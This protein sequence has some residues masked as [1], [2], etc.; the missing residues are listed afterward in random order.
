MKP[1][2]ITTTATSQPALS[3]SPVVVI[4][5]AEDTATPQQSFETKPLTSISIKNNYSTGGNASNPFRLLLETDHNYQNFYMDPTA[6]ARQRD[7]KKSNG[8]TSD[9]DDYNVYFDSGSAE[10]KSN[11]GGVN[12][13]GCQLKKIDEELSSSFSASSASLASQASQSKHLLPKT[14][15]G[16][17]RKSNKLVKL[18]TSFT[19]SSSSSSTI[20]TTSQ[21]QTTSTVITAQCNNNGGDNSL[22]SESIISTTAAA[23]L[24]PLPRN[25]IPYSLSL[26]LNN[27]SISD[28]KQQHNDFERNS[29]VRRSKRFTS[30]SNKQGPRTPSPSQ[31]AT[32]LANNA[33]HDAQFTAS[34]SSIAKNL[35]SSSASSSTSS[36]STTP[37][38]PSLAVTS[39]LSPPPLQ[40]SP[41]HLT[42][43][44]STPSI[45]EQLA[46]AAAASNVSNANGNIGQASLSARSKIRPRLSLND[47]STINAAIAAEQQLMHLQA[48]AKLDQLDL[49]DLSEA[50]DEDD[51]DVFVDSEERVGCCESGG[52]MMSCAVDYDQDGD[53]DGELMDD[54]VSFVQDKLVARRVNP[55]H[56]PMQSSVSLDSES[57]SLAV[58]SA[59]DNRNGSANSKIQ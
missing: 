11:C 30:S 25:S 38:P 29:S 21:Q 45:I 41:T 55:H 1:T 48:M 20:I 37:M 51:E 9:R 28:F 46:A 3:K 39:P 7:I 59:V 24:P 40:Q 8:S 26:A 22:L 56:R 42:K 5:A 53:V 49:E 47:Q 12:S 52:R 43:A 2:T 36:A 54:L 32:T 6:S 44:I 17:A 10:K 23:L 33:V 14:T 4:T 27:P 15:T 19:S 57:V 34:S 35:S 50:E 18:L 13:T 16:S 58:A 31:A